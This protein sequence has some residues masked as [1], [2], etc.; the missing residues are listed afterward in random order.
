MTDTH[1]IKIKPLTAAD[2]DA[3]HSLWQDYLTFYKTSLPANITQATWDKIL[4]NEVTIYGFGAWNGEAMVGIAHVVLH[5]NT[6]NNS[7][8]CYLEDLYVN[9]SVRGQGFGRAL[10]D[11]VYDFAREKGC[12]RVYWSTQSDNAVARTLYDN[13]ATLTDMVQYR[14]DL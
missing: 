1:T 5:P 3:W 9:N 8:C 11:Y 6:W 2:Y 7:D 4:D 13:I 14:K 12:N 10:I